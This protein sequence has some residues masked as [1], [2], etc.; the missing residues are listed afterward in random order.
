MHH[1][2]GGNKI[3]YLYFMVN[4]GNKISTT[5]ERIAYV[6]KVTNP[7]GQ[8]YIGST[9][10]PIKRK[11]AYKVNNKT[12]QRKI[13]ESVLKYGWENH[14]FEIIKECY[15][16]NARKYESFYGF[17]YGVLGENGLNCF[18]PKFDV[19]NES[20]CKD[21]L[22]KMKVASKN[23]EFC[24]LARDNAQKA[25]I[26]SKRMVGNKNR[27][28]VVL[29]IEMGI[30]YESAVAAAKVFNINLKTIHNILNPNHF[31]TNKTSLRYV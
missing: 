9:L 7:I 28:K 2:Y 11:S 19:K 23:R 30:Y 3:S 10:R 20:T 4:K 25:R 17:I 16:Y 13:C 18:L 31:H 6:Y 15:A 24:Q 8:I 21:T 22:E 1:I 29:D 14:S 27:A 12:G 26:G 5:D